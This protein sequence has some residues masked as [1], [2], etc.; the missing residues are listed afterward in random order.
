MATTDECI[1]SLAVTNGDTD[2][3]YKT[4]EAIMLRP[5]SDC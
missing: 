1:L 4:V 2:C 5:L 3:S